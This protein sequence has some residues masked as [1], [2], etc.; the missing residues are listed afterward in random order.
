MLNTLPNLHRSS[1]GQLRLK[2]QPD[3]WIHSLLAGGSL[4][5]G[6]FDQYPDL[7]FVVVVDP[8]YHD[9]IMTQCMVFIGTLGHLL[10][11]L[12]GEHVGESRPLIYLFGP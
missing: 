4:I 8:L 9:E 5:H 7:D 6:G 3:S 10:H 12:T 11:A 2:L 1:I